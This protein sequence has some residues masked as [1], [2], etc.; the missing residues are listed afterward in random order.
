M[1]PRR[2]SLPLH[3][4]RFPC[5][6]V[7][8]FLTTSS[9]FPTFLWTVKRIKAS[10]EES[11][12]SA[13]SLGVIRT[14]ASH[15][16][17]D[18]E[19][20]DD[21][22]EDNVEDSDEIV[23]QGGRG[24][25]QDDND[26]E[27]QEEEEDEDDEQDIG[28]REDDNHDVGDKDKCGGMEGGGSSHNESVAAKSQNV[29]KATVEPSAQTT[30]PST[31]A[32]VSFVADSLSRG[33]NEKGVV[34]TYSVPGSPWV[35]YVSVEFNVPGPENIE[36]VNPG[37]SARPLGDSTVET[38]A[39]G[40]EKSSTVDLWLIPSHPMSHLFQLRVVRSLWLSMSRYLPHLVAGHLLLSKSKKDLKVLRMR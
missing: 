29:P 16:S 37:D 17:V 32:K 23:D 35:F 27:D 1:F 34:D 7:L 36:T 9:Y 11:A 2:E 24:Y 22:E 30:A 33:E 19:E 12:A 14:T 21:E 26:E 10:T 6:L 4:Y 15:Q 18:G 39:K 3:A 20:G 31:F 38:P 8:C 25:E 40:G 5:F 28:N 13:S